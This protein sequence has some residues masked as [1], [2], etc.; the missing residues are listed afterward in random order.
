MNCFY[1]F[2]KQ[3]KIRLRKD[4]LYLSYCAVVSE[5]GLCLIRSSALN[6]VRKHDENVSKFLSDSRKKS[7]L[8]LIVI[9]VR[10]CFSWW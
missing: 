9:T 6:F 1:C 5:S 4:V 3:N 10:F 8:N 2:T 7:K